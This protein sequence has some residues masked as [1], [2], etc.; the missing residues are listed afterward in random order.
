MKNYKAL[1]IMAVSILASTQVMADTSSA[2]GTINFS[3]AITDTTCTINGGKSADF[4]VALSPISVT[5]AGTTANSVITKNKKSISLTFS[6]CSPAGANANSALKIYFSSAQN[7]SNDGR[8]LINNS[9]NE[10]DQAVA[11]N[12][13][14]ALTNSGSTTPIQLNQPLTTT[15]TGS[16]KAPSA[17]TLNLDVYYYK[18]NSQAAKVG[19]VNSSLIYTVSYL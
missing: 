2:G 14:F 16:S 13:G 7:I 18:P 8:Y 15:L 12:V 6:D 1:S 9:V 3:G 19:A 10:N 5:D 11:K 4:S 17:E